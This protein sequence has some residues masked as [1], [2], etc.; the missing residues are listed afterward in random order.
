M[1]WQSSKIPNVLGFL[2]LL[3][4]LAHQWQLLPVDTD[5]MKIVP[6]KG[7]NMAMSKSRP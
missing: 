5:T 3:D 4:Y 2:R 7:D 6:A 1:A